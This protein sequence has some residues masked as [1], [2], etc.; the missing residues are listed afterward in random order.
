MSEHRYDVVVLGGGIGGYTAAIR[1]AQLGKTVAV[2]E[3]AKLGGTCLHQ[4]CI[5][6]KALLRSAEVYATMKKSE[7]YGI[8]SG[9]LELKFESVLARKQ[10]IVDQLHQ[11]LQFLMKK[12]KITVHTGNGRII[13]P[14]IFSPRSG[15]VSVE[16][17]D[18]D[19]ETLL[20]S[21][22]VIATGSRPRS[23]PGLTI[24]GTHIMTSEDALRMQE[25]PK[26][27]IIIGGG[28]IGVEWASMLCD[29]GVEVTIVE[30][31]KRLVSLEDAD[32]SKE[33]ERLFKKRGINLVTGAKV[34]PDSVKAAEGLVTLQADKQ[35]E[36]I[37]L[38]AE[39]VL[40]SIGREANIE[41]IGLEN[42]DIKVDKG[43]IRVNRFMQT[44]ESHIYAVG[45]VIGGL[46]LAHMAGHEGILASEHIAGQTPHEL[47]AHLVSKCTYTRPEIASVGYTEQQAT[48]LGHQV[49]VGKFSFKGIGKALVYGDTDGFVKVIADS[50][51]NDILGVHMIGPHVTNSI[52]EAALAQVLNATPWEVGQTI[53]PHPTL[54]EALGEAMLAVDG[55]AISG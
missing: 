42:T 38:Q 37:D 5:P 54:S 23:L 18:G 43:V 47:H 40:V 10:R 11:G 49:K 29:F 13:G 36:I 12:N 34:L 14:S 17:E 2:V 51:T 45:D 30:Y 27:I 21:N 20:S 4:G 26:S 25:L 22:L 9:S 48:E 24:D 44:T 16:K 50:E 46:M 15:A 8:A 41:G 6:S 31:E 1:A 39:K 52:S 7:E 32:V 28:V 35:G 3:R 19:I 55:I 53:H 33:L